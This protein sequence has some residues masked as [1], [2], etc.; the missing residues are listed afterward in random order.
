[1]PSKKTSSKTGKTNPA[2][3]RPSRAK[4][5]KKAS[6]TEL[7]TP[8]DGADVERASARDILTARNARSCQES[9]RCTPAEHN[10]LLQEAKEAGF[11]T[12]TA[13]WRHKIGL[14]A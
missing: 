4:S 2:R 5:T 7:P 10:A 12:L 11:S 6:K 13:F 3:K 14:P 8:T 1:M 9:F